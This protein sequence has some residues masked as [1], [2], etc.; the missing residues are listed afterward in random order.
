MALKCLKNVECTCFVSSMNSTTSCGVLFVLLSFL[1]Y[2]SLCLS[3]CLSLSLSLSFVS[4]QRAVQRS[5]R[6][7]LGSAAGEPA[8]GAGDRPG[9]GTAVAELA[10]SHAAAAQPGGV[11]GT[12]REG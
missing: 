7:L 2:L 9:A 4:L 1:F 3:L 8:R 6:V 12:Y 5:V 10:G 11:H